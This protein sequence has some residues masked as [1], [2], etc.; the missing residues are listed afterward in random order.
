MFQPILIVIFFI[1]TDEKSG[2]DRQGFAPLSAS[3][4]LQAEKESDGS[5]GGKKRRVIK[6]YFILRR[7]KEVETGKI[8]S[9]NKQIV[10]HHTFGFEIFVAYIFQQHADGLNSHF[11]D[12]HPGN[13]HFGR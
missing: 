4:L 5:G 6:P 13:T 7:E 9:R 10:E 2:L 8:K 11:F 1:F 12:R 3:I